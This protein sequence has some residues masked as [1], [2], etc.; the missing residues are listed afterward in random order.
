[1]KTLQGHW[2]QIYQTKSTSQM[3][4]TQGVPSTSLQLIQLTGVSKHDRIIDV[5]G[6]MS[7]LVDHLLDLGFSQLTVADISDIALQKTQERLGARSK[8]V[9]W[10]AGDITELV[11]PTSHY[12]IWHD[13][14]VFH[15]LSDEN[16]RKAYK[17]NLM[18]SLK[19]GGWAIL[20]TFSTEGPEKCSGL[21]VV[22]YDEHSLMKELG[23]RFTLGEVVK[24]N[25]K[26]P[27]GDDQ[28]FI[29]I[30]ARLS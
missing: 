18:R 15:F 21:S 17:E 10:F 19:K 13:R 6:G 27:W 29:S 23:P 12:D 4:W 5:G 7:T 11:L 30:S 25:H 22:R 2:N 26:T 24:E 9:F 8:S 28:A 20:S 16:K 1:M 14:A 3:S